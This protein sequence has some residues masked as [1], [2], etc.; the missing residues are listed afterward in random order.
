MASSVELKRVEKRFGT[1]EAVKAVSLYIEP[2]ELAVFVGPSGCGKSTLLRL[3]AGLEAP[4]AGAIHIGERDVTYVHPSKRGIAMVFQSYALYPHM[5]VAQ[6]MAF[7]LEIRGVKREEV[8]AKVARAADI[9]QLTELLDRKP[10]A[11]SGGQRQRAAIGRAIV[12]E[13]EVFLLDEPLSNLDAALRGQVRV[14]LARLHARLGAT[15]I[16]VT[17]DQVEAMTLASKIVVVNGGRVEQ[18]GAPLELY[19]RPANAFVAGFLGSPRMNFLEGSVTSAHARQ[20]VVALP[21]GPVLLSRN[22]AGLAAGERVTLGV[23]PEDLR[24]LSDGS[25]YR[26][27]LEGRLVLAERLGAETLVHVALDAASE[28]VPVILKIV[29][30][31][32]AGAPGAKLRLAIDPDKCHLF[33]SEGIAVSEPEGTAIS[34]IAAKLPVS[35]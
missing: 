18:V 27:A 10:R 9:L 22:G 33:D 21:S 35:A 7:G 20:V 30:D 17:H 29:G 15:M 26:N 25:S 28:A 3:I 23:R 1:V 19:H 13:P 12:R 2:G 6:N 32:P 16:Y 34:E 11:L 5:S 31:L 4:S 8:R 14:E 24:V